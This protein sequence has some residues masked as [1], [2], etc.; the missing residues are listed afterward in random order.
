[1]SPLP[2]IIIA[3]FC[4][5]FGQVGDLAESLLKREADI[6]DSGDI[7]PGHGGMLDRFDSILVNSVLVFIVFGVLW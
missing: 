1:M 4:G 3:L 7:I 6:K 5:T 2:I